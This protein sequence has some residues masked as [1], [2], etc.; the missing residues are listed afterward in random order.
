[1]MARNISPVNR[2]AMTRP[3][4]QATLDSADSSTV[5]ASSR[6]PAAPGSPPRARRNRWISSAVSSACSRTVA[7]REGAMP[8]DTRRKSE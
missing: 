8:R 4:N 5:T 2:S 6:A 3:L 1:M 7:H